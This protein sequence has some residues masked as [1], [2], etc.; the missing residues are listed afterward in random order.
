MI[1]VW[2]SLQATMTN[3]AG[4]DMEVE[5]VRSGPFGSVKSEWRRRLRPGADTLPK[6]CGWGAA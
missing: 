6:T 2:A 1:D 4:R 3:C 5:E